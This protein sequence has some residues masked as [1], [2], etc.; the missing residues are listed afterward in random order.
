LWWTLS[1]CGTYRPFPVF[2]CT[3]SAFAA[4]ISCRLAEKAF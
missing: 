2:F 4:V 1:R 3:F